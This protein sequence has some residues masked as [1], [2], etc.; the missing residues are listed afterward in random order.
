[1]AAESVPPLLHELAMPQNSSERNFPTISSCTQSPTILQSPKKAHSVVKSRTLRFPQISLLPGRVCT[2]R[3]GAQTS[4]VRASAFQ[5][6]R[7]CGPCGCLGF[8]S[9]QRAKGF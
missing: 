7:V 6:R 1:M 8:A 2:A 4:G 3:C 9:L 5:G